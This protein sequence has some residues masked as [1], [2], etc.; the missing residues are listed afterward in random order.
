MSED[1]PIRLP[2]E[3]LSKYCS[4]IFMALGMTPQEARLVTECLVQADLRGIS[5]HGVTRMGIY[6]KRL[7]LGLI[8]S[9]PKIKVV[10]ETPGTA[11]VD[12][13]NG[14]GAVVGARAMEIAI[15]KAQMTGVGVVGVRNSNH[16]GIAAFYAMQA[17]EKNMIGFSMTNAP[18]TMAPWGGIT[19]MIGTNPVAVAVPAGHE[20]PIVFD[21]STST[22]ARGKIILAE[23]E[24]KEIPFGWAVDKLGRPTSNP[25]EALE[26][27]VLP[28]G[29]AKGYGISVI[30]DIL[31]GVLT[32]ALF[33][34]H[35]NS[36]YEN[37]SEPQNLGHFFGA[38][39]VEAFMPSEEFKRRIDQVIRE[40]KASRRAYGVEE[41]FLPGEIEFRAEEDQRRHGV[42]LSRVVYEELLALGRSL[43]IEEDLTVNRGEGADIDPAVE[44]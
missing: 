44:A 40:I 18:A 12:G 36:L 30:I 9:H 17:L 23:K 7:R 16:Y 39:D 6:A 21:M 35:I 32:G 37:F 3:E 41:I 34:C 38:I 42:K 8:S 26:G 43:G 13:D 2:A 25:R 28:L 24:G 20:Y 19:P 11:L 29:G 5:S 33:G 1:S 10:R 15:R 14:M 27:A 31:C 22:V 4:K